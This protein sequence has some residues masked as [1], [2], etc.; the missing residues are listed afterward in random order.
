M[1]NLCDPSDPS[2]F[3]KARTLAQTFFSQPNGESQHTIHAMGHCHIDSGSRPPFFCHIK[4]RDRPWWYK[5][6]W[7]NSNLKEQLCLHALVSFVWA[8]LVK[9]KVSPFICLD[10][11]HADILS[12]RPLFSG[13][14]T[15]LDTFLSGITLSVGKLIIRLNLQTGVFW[16][17]LFL[18]SADFSCSLFLKARRNKIC[19]TFEN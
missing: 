13:W 9:A 17:S 3:S 15:E 12:V 11:T 8:E 5:N 1:V 16:K 18:G 10:P 14:E 2:S 19:A 6:I 7:E 4:M